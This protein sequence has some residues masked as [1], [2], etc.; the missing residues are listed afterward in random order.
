MKS[1]SSGI[2]LDAPWEH[3][4]EIHSTNQYLMDLPDRCIRD[5]Y[6]CSSDIQTAGKGRMGRSW[7]SPSGGVY[8]SVLFRSNTQVDN[9]G[10]LPFMA[11]VAAGKALTASIPHLDI[12][13]KW[14]NDLLIRTR[15]TGGVLIQSRGRERVVIGI[16]INV[17]IDPDEF[18]DRPAFPIT[19]LHLETSHPP[20]TGTLVYSC[21]L[22]LLEQYIRLKTNPESIRMDWL[23]QSATFGKKILF[24]VNGQSRHGVDCGIN[25]NGAIQ[26]ESGGMMHSFHSL[27]IITIED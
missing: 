23:Q 27:E 7:F 5:G 26:V 3:F 4:N 10:L 14:P 12:R 6:T 11:A 24:T 19:S 22:H 17:Q 21:R 25:E 16:G 8:L 1:D 13:F 15:K 20:Q 9:F 2:L 18:P